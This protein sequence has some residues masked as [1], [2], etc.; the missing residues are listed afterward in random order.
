MSTELITLLQRIQGR[1]ERF[2]KPTEEPPKPSADLKRLLGR[3]ETRRWK[4]ESLIDL[5]LL[6]RDL[7]A[8]LSLMEHLKTCRQCQLELTI[9]VE[10][11]YGNHCGVWYLDLMNGDYLP[12]YYPDCPKAE[13]YEIGSYW[14]GTSDGTIKFIKDRIAWAEKITEKEFAAACKLIAVLENWPVSKGIPE[15]SWV[16]GMVDELA[17]NPTLFW[18]V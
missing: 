12:E 4:E 16:R 14:S 2:T 7:D 15:N 5:E 3:M 1:R 10:R 18:G 6:I 9:D 13:N 17:G 8:D 11:Y